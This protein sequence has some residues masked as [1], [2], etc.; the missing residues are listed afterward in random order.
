MGVAILLLILAIAAGG[1]W[2]L[3]RGS[4][5]PR[6]SVTA[7]N[8]P[9]QNS[10]EGTPRRPGRMINPGEECCGAS[11]R[12]ATTWYPEGGVPRLP[13]EGCEHPETCK[14]AWMR[15]LDRRSTYRRSDHD[16]R[17]SVRFEDK[18]DRRAGQ[19]RRKDGANPWKNT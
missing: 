1:F 17:G 19:D 5:K 16:R 11:R 9:V 13:L 7:L 15:V 14:C 18:D 2:Y 6:S 10:A 12:V 8:L 4:A 3:R